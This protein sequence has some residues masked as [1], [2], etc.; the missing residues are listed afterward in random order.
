MNNEV[1]I[2]QVKVV[3]IL[4]TVTTHDIV[5][6]EDRSKLSETMRD[7]VQRCKDALGERRSHLA[8][9]SPSTL[10]RAKH[11][12]NIEFKILGLED[13]MDEIQESHFGFPSP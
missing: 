13:I 4:G 1:R 6:P 3:T 9:P 2:L 10:Y 11:I 7:L 8:M 12:V 5:A